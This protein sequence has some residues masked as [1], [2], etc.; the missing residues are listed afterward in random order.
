ATPASASVRGQAML[1]IRAGTM[2]RRSIE[3]VGEDDITVSVVLHR[4][5]IA[6]RTAGTRT[7]TAEAAALVA[8]LP[9]AAV[10]E[11]QRFDQRTSGL[12]V[13]AVVMQQRL[14]VRPRFCVDE[15]LA[16]GVE[17]ATTIRRQKV[18]A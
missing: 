14:D 18:G 16:E 17:R 1:R 6:M 4:A 8:A 13:V 5:D 15:I 10:A 7:A 12:Q 9:M 3:T 2:T 11:R